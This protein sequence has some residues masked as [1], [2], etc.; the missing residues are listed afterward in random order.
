[1]RDFWF[2]DGVAATPLKETLEAGS[3]LWKQDGDAPALPVEHQE[4]VFYVFGCGRNT[5]CGIRKEGGRWKMLGT[6]RGDGTVTWD[7]GKI[8]G[9]P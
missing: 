7:S 8:D 9:H 3:W 1:M 2:G 5:P 4:K 6:P